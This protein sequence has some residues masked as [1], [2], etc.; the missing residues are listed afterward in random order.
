[1]SLAT[2]TETS[3]GRTRDDRCWLET[4]TGWGSPVDTNGGPVWFSRPKK[5]LGNTGLLYTIVNECVEFEEAAGRR[6]VGPRGAVCGT[7]ISFTVDRH[8][9]S[10]LLCTQSQPELAHE[11]TASTHP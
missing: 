2:Y 6:H 11:R 3:A 9:V 10:T 5:R 8:H 7:W 1:V 4:H